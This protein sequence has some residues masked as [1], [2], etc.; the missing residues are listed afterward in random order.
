MPSPYI[1]GLPIT[2]TI[3]STNERG[4]HSEEIVRPTYE[5]A[6][7]LEYQAWHEVLRG[8]SPAKTTASDGECGIPVGLAER[9]LIC[10]QRDKTSRSSP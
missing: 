1:K 7:T 9:C 6:Y 3:L 10:L 2:T 8:V 4:D 5:D